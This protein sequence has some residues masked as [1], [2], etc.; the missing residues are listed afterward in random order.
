MLCIAT[1]GS[2]RERGQQH[3][4]KCADLIRTIQAHYSR[5]GLLQ[6]DPSPILRT[7]A[8][9]FPALI[10]EMEGIAEG[11]DLLKEQVFRMNLQLLDAGP[12]CSMAA[13]LGTDGDP[14]ILKTDDIGEDQLG[15]NV[16]KRDTLAS[17]TRILRLHFAGTIWTSAAFTDK[18][19]CMGMT[20]LAGEAGPLSGLPPLALLHVLPERCRTVTEA[21]AFLESYALN[22]G[23]ISLFL[24][25]AEKNL[26]LAEK[27]VH[28]QC[29]QRLRSSDETLCHTNH[30]R[31]GGLD[32]PPGYLNT[33][34]GRNSLARLAYLETRVPLLPRSREGLQSI[35]ADHTP[36]GGICQHGGGGLHTDYAVILSPSMHG[37]W[38]TKGPPCRA[39][40]EFEKV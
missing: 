40:F 17:G 26:L 38:L 9:S 12:S 35:F 3:G 28:G 20:G 2:P 4:A 34:L 16:L 10:E 11:A 27:N 33:P 8:S 24:A 13:I 5:K 14:W 6:M 36:L 23:G 29:A 7:L 15:F 19:F 1:K 37:I 31:L 21:E 25:D 32:N 39:P 30:A 22:H 18:G